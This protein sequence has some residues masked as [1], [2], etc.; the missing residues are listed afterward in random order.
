MHPP[1]T[2]ANQISTPNTTLTPPPYHDPVA[3]ARTRYTM[4]CALL[5]RRHMLG[6]DAVAA[7]AVDAAAAAATA[8]DGSAF[9]NAIVSDTATDAAAGSG[10]WWWRC[11]VYSVSARLG[12][13][14]WWGW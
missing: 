5:P 9:A 10:W 8:V 1:A 3:T 6:A 11:G 7:A 13:V 12:G 14:W 2:T 4:S